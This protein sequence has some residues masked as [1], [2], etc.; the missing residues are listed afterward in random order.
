[1]I[2]IKLIVL[3]SLTLFS[4]ELMAA[5]PDQLFEID[6]AFEDAIMDDGI[7]YLAVKNGEGIDPDLRIF[8]MGDKE[9][10]V[11]IGS[12]RSSEYAHS[13]AKKGNYLF[14]INGRFGLEVIDVSNPENP[15]L[16]HVMSL[17]GY[18]HKIVIAG[19]LAFVAAGFEGMHILDISKPEDPK[20]LSTFQ[21]YA[22]PQDQ[23][24]FDV[25][26]TDRYVDTEDYG[27]E[28]EYSGGGSVDV[29]WQDIATSEGALD[30]AVRGSYAYIAY[31][32]EGIVVAD[33]SKPANPVKV[34]TTGLKNPAESIFLSHN[35]L[36][37]TIG[38]EGM[39]LIDIAHPETPNILSLIHTRCY[40]RDVSVIK[41]R[42]FV[43]DGVCAEDS[44]YVVSVADNRHPEVEQAFSGK[45]NN[46]KLLKHAILAMGPKHVQAFTLEF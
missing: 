20:L 26:S 41:E 35:T 2:L 3:I 22:P 45:V 6:G 7:L 12:Y 46:V 38:L 1:L 36:Y 17:N 37:A 5:P 30:V 23:D 34:S 8:R 27:D 13:L 42:A 16:V 33:V 28:R 18:T 43:A 31:G 11:E 40:P 15:D 24:N 14:L 10:P 19:D 4:G 25:D 21:A 29:T 32:S 39:N 9:G 44:L